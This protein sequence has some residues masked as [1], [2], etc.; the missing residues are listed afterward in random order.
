[1][2]LPK[3]ILLVEDEAITRIV[4]Q[5][6][7]E[8]EGHQITVCNNAAE[9]W[10]V[11]LANPKHFDLV[12]LDR[13]L[14]DSDGMALLKQIK[15]EPGF[16]HTPVIFETAQ[17]DQQSIREGLDNGAYYYLTKPFQPDVL[18]AVV[19]AALQQ[20]HEY[21][22]L[23]ASIKS[24]E[25]LL[26]LMTQGHFHFRDLEQARMLANHLARLCPHPECAVQGL[27]ELL[28]N[29]VEHGNL[30]I[31]YAEKNQLLMKGEWQQEI[32]RRLQLPEYRDRLV[33]VSFEKANK[34]ICITIQDQGTGFN[35]QD[36]L[37]F[38]PDRAFDLNGRGIALAYKLSIDQLQY[39][40]NGNTVKACF[41]INPNPPSPDQ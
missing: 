18:L 7:L 28:I 17:S 11:L 30:A 2:S 36:Y 40:G 24:A 21:Q 34:L 25:N 3:Q 5:D 22:E 13:G 9:A 27:Q 12:L 23:V 32:Q 39:L 29:A 38:S 6:L 16:L 37:D 10:E 14:P 26:D 41:S 15:Q 33:E 4:I 20:S 31:S 19:K 1:M 35:W 8:T